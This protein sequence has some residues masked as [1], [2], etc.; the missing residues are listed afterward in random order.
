MLIVIPRTTNKKNEIYPVIETRRE[1]KWYIRKHLTQK[2][3]ELR[4]NNKRYKT[5]SKQ[6][7][8]QK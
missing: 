5:Y 4:N 2:K 3:E 6:I 7:T 1:S 8:W